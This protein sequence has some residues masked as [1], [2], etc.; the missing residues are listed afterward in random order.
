VLRYEKAI[1]PALLLTLLAAHVVCGETARS[2]KLNESKHPETAISTAPAAPLHSA[3][4]D[5]VKCHKGHG[6]ED[7][8]HAGLACADCHIAEDALAEPNAS[9]IRCHPTL[10]PG[11]PELAVFR[12]G[13]YRL[14]LRDSLLRPLCSDCHAGGMHNFARIALT[15]PVRSVGEHLGCLDCHDAAGRTSQA[16]WGKRDYQA[17]FCYG[18]HKQQMRDFLPGGGHSPV[19]GRV[20]CAYCHPPHEPMQANLTLDTLELMGEGIIAAYDS[21][22]SNRRCL[23]CHIYLDLTGSRSRFVYPGG[24]SLHELHLEQ[25]AASCVECHDP[26]VS[27]TGAMLRSQLLSGE[28]MVRMVFGQTASCTVMCHGKHHRSVEYWRGDDW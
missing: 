2:D 20:R 5:C 19:Q 28:V 24:L 23:K 15:H 21:Q 26:H 11:L 18:C 13:K 9:C 17:K 3:A 27:G 8:P 14:G 4:A 6:L 7:S 25:A 22:A 16:V 1:L 12:T 10:A